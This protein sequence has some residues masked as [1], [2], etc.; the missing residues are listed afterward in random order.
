MYVFGFG[1]EHNPDCAWARRILE[2]QHLRPSARLDWLC[3][4]AVYEAGRQGRP[5]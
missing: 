2:Q 3:S 1:F 5:K 4:R